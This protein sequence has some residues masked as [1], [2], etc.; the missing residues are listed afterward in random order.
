MKTIVVNAAAAP[1]S[2][3]TYVSAYARLTAI[4][5]KLKGGGA[6]DVDTLVQDLR[7]ARMAYS[8]CKSRLDAIRREVDAEVEA[9][10]E[11]AR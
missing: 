2:T 9:A 11:V 6:T 10:G 1:S 4:A 8:I 7:E 5:D 3:E